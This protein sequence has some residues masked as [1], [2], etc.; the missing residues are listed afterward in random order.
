MTF[1]STETSRPVGSWTRDR[2]PTAVPCGSAH[3]D[4]AV[5]SPSRPGPESLRFREV[6]I[7]RRVVAL[8]LSLLALPTALAAVTPSGR[9]VDENGV[10]IAGAA[11]GLEEAMLTLTF[12]GRV[13]ELT[14]LTDAEG[15]FE[16]ADV[17]PGLY[18]LEVRAAGFAPAKVLKLLPNKHRSGFDLGTVALAPPSRMNGRCWHRGALRCQRKLWSRPHPMSS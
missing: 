1:D 5:V 16:I 2:F 15:R 13:N 17:A 9:V 18:N 4:H 10:P 12:D 6:H 8:T 14:Y 3:R 7:F 11:V